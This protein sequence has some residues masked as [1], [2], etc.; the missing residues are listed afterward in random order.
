MEPSSLTDIINKIIDREVINYLLNN[1]Y[2][3]LGVYALGRLGDSITTA[4][5][6][7]DPSS[8]TMLVSKFFMERFGV[9]K[10]SVITELVGLAFLLGSYTFLSSKGWERSD[11][12]IIPYIMAAGSIGA[13]FYNL[14]HYLQQ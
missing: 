8:E 9:L 7:H 3:A 1:T 5:V 13:T 14:L 6:V 11:I 12:N 10:G 4:L 2:L